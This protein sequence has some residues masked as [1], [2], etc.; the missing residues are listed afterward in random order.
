MICI[1]CDL[2]K[3]SSDEHVIPESIGGCIHVYKVCKE[4]N[5]LFGQTVDVVVTRHRHI[6]D[7]Y[8]PIRGN[9]GV[10]DLR[11]CSRTFS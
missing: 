7:A 8:I 4:C 3:P 6:Y 11:P 10:P 9:K 2:E 1:F 5:D